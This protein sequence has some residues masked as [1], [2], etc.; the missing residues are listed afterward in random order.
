M[1]IASSSVQPSHNLSTLDMCG[2]SGDCHDKVA[3]HV[4]PWLEKATKNVLTWQN[5][6]AIFILYKLLLRIQYLGVQCQGRGRKV[7]CLSR[8][9]PYRTQRSFL[10]LTMHV[11]SD[12]NM[13]NNVWAAEIIGPNFS[14][15]CTEKQFSDLF[16]SAPGLSPDLAPI[17][18]LNQK[19]L[20]LQFWK[21]EWGKGI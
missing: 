18:S 3:K 12:R 17:T 4:L 16:A 8:K 13:W 2:Q 14:R 10:F 9:D 6:I 7:N 15:T 1:S 11:V 5:H 21:H 20:A 19:L